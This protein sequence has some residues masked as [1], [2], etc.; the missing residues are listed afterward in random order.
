MQ[1]DDFGDKVT[2]ILKNQTKNDSQSPPLNP[3]PL[4]LGITLT[5]GLFGDTILCDNGVHVVE[6]QPDG[7]TGQYLMAAL[8]N[9]D[10][11]AKSHIYQAREIA[12][13]KETKTQN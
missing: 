5:L 11:K 6:I 4:N 10:A 9:L 8:H 1:Q 7:P 13:T 3:P 2:E 12:K